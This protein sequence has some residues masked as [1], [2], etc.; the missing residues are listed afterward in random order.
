MTPLHS[1]TTFNIITFT[2]TGHF[3]RDKSSAGVYTSF[4]TSAGTS[5]LVDGGALIFFRPQASDNVKSNVCIAP[6]FQ[7]MKRGSNPPLHFSILSSAS[8][9][10]PMRGAM[11]GDVTPNNILLIGG[12]RGH[13]SGSSLDPESHACWFSLTCAYA[14]VQSATRI[15]SPESFTTGR[16]F[17]SFGLNWTW[18]RSS[19]PIRHLKLLLKSINIQSGSAILP[20]NLSSLA[21]PLSS[22]C[23]TQFSTEQSTT[24]SKLTYNTEFLY[25]FICTSGDAN[26][27]TGPYTTVAKS[28]SRWTRASGSIRIITARSVS[29]GIHNTACIHSLP[30]P[31]YLLL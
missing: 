20:N 29:K 31:P 16:R 1:F 25:A 4:H 27:I 2:S 14:S 21:N 17:Q 8:R 11:A 30:L 3:N 18:E 26:D 12:Y 13:W 9:A 28:L 6:T 22:I 7:L 10:A 24:E 15:A 19:R 5:G 23:S